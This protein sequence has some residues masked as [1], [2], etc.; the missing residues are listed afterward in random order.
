MLF[1]DNDPTF[2]IIY[3]EIILSDTYDLRAC[4]QELDIIVDIGANVGLFSVYARM[5]YPTARIIAIEPCKKSYE[6]L[7]KNVQGL[8]IETYNF[9]LGNN[10]KLYL[11]EQ[12]QGGSNKF[13]ESQDQGES[14]DSFDLGTLFE[15]FKIDAGKDR[16]FIKSDCEGGEQYLLNDD[17]A[18]NIIKHAIQLSMEVHFPGTRSSIFNHLPQ[19]TIIND[20]IKNKF[21][22]THE[23]KYWHSSKRIGL[24]TYVLKLI[25]S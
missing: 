1:S 15:K 4:K 13:L 10:K 6:Y 17:K 24:G 5:H 20:W 2:S 22:K 8:H 19:Y 12:K 14:C 25:K 16:Y 3:R 7:V 21:S 9:A 18:E 23:I 11:I